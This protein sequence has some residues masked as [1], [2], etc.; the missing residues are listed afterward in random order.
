MENSTSLAVSN[1]TIMEEGTV[2]L[3]FLTARNTTV[4]RAMD[5][6]SL[7]SLETPDDLRC[8][9]TTQL[10]SLLLDHN[11]P[12]KCNKADLVPR[13]YALVA[14]YSTHQSIES[15]PDAESIEETYDRLIISGGWVC[16]DKGSP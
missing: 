10:R 13:C 14:R 6:I 3:S 1:V 5:Y 4:I 12:V 11:Q 2:D 16:L 7:S 15:S 8:L 9:N